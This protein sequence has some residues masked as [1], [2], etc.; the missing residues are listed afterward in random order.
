MQGN[1]VI[2]ARARKK[3][4]GDWF[5]DWAS[6]DLKAV[7]YREEYVKELCD[8]DAE[9]LDYFNLGPLIDTTPSLLNTVTLYVG[10]GLVTFLPVE[11]VNPAFTGLPLR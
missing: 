3:E 4:L 2:D 11:A 10:F 7:V 9:D 6:S 5:E 8:C 1:K